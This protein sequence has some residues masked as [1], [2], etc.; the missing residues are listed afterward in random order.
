MRLRRLTLADVPVAAQLAAEAFGGGAR[1]ARLRRYLTLEPEGWFA[2]EDAGTLL[3]TGGVVRYPGF[4]WLGLMAVRPGRQREGLGRTVAGAAIDWAR[5]RG[6]PTVCLIAT[7][8]GIPL[9]Q[10]LG[11]AP[12]G[13]SS[14]LA[15][16][17]HLATPTEGPYEVHPWRPADT[18]GV[19]RFDAPA[20]GADRSH[21][22]DAYVRDFSRSAWV[23][24]DGA[25]A[26]RGFLVV[27]DE[28]IGPWA[29]SDETA[30]GQLLDVGL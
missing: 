26:L 10:H 6:C 27:Q 30:A 8:A 7:P 11:F 24:R 20:F 21:L 4:A 14:E 9:Y 1:E 18:T 17:P 16:V 25:G 23:A 12:D 28:S 5:A 22:L 3:A 19:A 2:V 13:D 15:G 29:A